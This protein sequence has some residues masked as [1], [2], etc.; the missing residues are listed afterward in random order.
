M[1]QVGSQNMITGQWWTALFPGI[2]LGLTILGYS[3]TADY[4]RVYLDPVNG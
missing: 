4:L 1:I 2:A 3:L